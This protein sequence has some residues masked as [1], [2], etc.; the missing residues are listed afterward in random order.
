MNHVDEVLDPVDRAPH[1]LIAGTPP[2]SMFNE[3]LQIDLLF[4]DD[5]IALHVTGVFPRNSS[6]TPVR[7]K[8]LRHVRGAF[9]GL[10]VGVFGPPECVQMN[11]GSE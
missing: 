10:R 8:T 3:K 4:L 7:V 11:V 6:P 5:I 9:S 2:A 1:V